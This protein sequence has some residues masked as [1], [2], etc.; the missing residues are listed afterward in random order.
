MGPKFSAGAIIQHLAKLRTKM[1]EV[2]LTVPPPLK[3]GITTKETSKIYTVG[4]NKKR[5]PGDEEA[6][7]RAVQNANATAMANAPV[8]G[9]NDTTP[10]A[11]R[12][13]SRKKIKKELSDDED[14]DMQEPELYDSD[15]DYGVPKK[16][17]KKNHKKKP[18][19][20]RSDSSSSPP[21]IKSEPD[22]DVKADIAPAGD[23]RQIRPDY[24]ELGNGCDDDEEADETYEEAY[25]APPS[26][27]LNRRASAGGFSA[28]ED[29]DQKT[30][31]PGS[32]SA[33]AT[34]KSKSKSPPKF[35]K[36]ENGRVQV[37]NANMMPFP[38]H[39]PYVSVS[40][41]VRLPPSV[42]IASTPHIH[43][44][45]LAPPCT[46]T[47]TDHLQMAN[48]S[49][50]SVPNF[51]FI[52]GNGNPYTTATYQ[53]F[54]NTSNYVNPTNPYPFAPFQAGPP[55]NAF[56][57]SNGSGRRGT[58]P[59]TIT[60]SSPPAT[61]NKGRTG[62]TSSSSAGSGNDAASMAATAAAA[63]L[64]GEGTT[65]LSLL[66]KPAPQS[67]LAAMSVNPYK[68]DIGYSGLNLDSNV[69]DMDMTMPMPMPL[70]FDFGGSD[71]FGGFD[72]NFNDTQP[73]TTHKGSKAIRNNSQT[74]V[75]SS[76]STDSIEQ[77]IDVPVPMTTSSG[78]YTDFTF[79]GFDS[80]GQRLGLGMGK[81]DEDAAA[82]VSFNNLT[83][84]NYGAMKGNKGKF[85]V[86]TDIKKR[87]KG[88]TANTG[89][90]K[91]TRKGKNKSKV[92]EKVYDTL[93]PPISTPA[94]SSN[95]DANVSNTSASHTVNAIDP[96]SFSDNDDLVGDESGLF[97]GEMDK[98]GEELFDDFIH[99]S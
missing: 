34:P 93:P 15:G 72:N 50:F 87:V 14:E 81:A 49:P 30:I 61:G 78:S 98:G 51:P 73:T 53:D 62:S 17:A 28:T 23:A 42:L 38:G 65:S 55:F 31:V 85:N 24:S 27:I 43:S 29:D 90:G 12:G 9:E 66:T 88:N 6:F 32:V 16:K 45:S 39:N 95:A 11:R 94:A 52:A 41:L 21:T 46:S 64:A 92:A 67:V 76:S 13:K 7:A 18:S 59:G 75:S 89:N 84:A 20:K 44:L 57:Q 91:G 79:D 47:F 10:P 8:E 69:L 58:F 36:D 1:Q 86:A 33:P 26:P 77:D 74:S 71:D 40:P 22:E 96:F 80:A 68:N 48:Q 2:G 19:H 3:K 56:I 83:T 99:S 54:S 5:K 70:N 60:P 63:A 82:G 35:I 37:G 4:N 97:S 25:D